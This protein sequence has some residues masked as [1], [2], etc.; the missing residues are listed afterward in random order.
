VQR[1]GVTIGS[2]SLGSTGVP[3]T[4]YLDVTAKPS[5]GYSYAV[6]ARDVA[7]NVSPPSTPVSVTTPASTGLPTLVQSAASS[8][9]TLIL[10]GPSAPGDLLV[11]TAG[12]YTGTSKRITAVS[13][14]RN[15]WTRAGAY[16]VAGQNSDGE[17]WYAA[18]AASV[19]TITVTTTA[20]VALQLQE[21][22]N[23]ASASVIDGVTGAVA[24]SRSPSSGLVTPTAGY[25]L[26]VG[27]ITG[28]ANAQVINVT[29]PGYR[30][31]PQQNT[32]NPSKVSVLSGYQVLS[33]L[34]AQSIAGTLSTA[35]YWTAGV[36]LFK[37]GADRGRAAAAS[38]RS[39]PII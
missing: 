13:D 5:T 19:R 28:H 27:F 29:S 2:A 8:T 36:A 26:A 37:A 34:T 33:G 30:L 23:M 11:L 6:I 31:Q 17:I 20:S 15:T 38:R 14:G 21:F 7:G 18:N 4:S 10:A 32:T 22:T 39:A 1:N 24:S 12:V 25:D 3:L 35:M 9:T 16:T